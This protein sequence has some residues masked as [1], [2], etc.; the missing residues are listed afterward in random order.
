MWVTAGTSGEFDWVRSTLAEN[1]VHGS[2][3]FGYFVNRPHLFRPSE[4]DERAAMPVL[5]ELL[6]SL[7]DGKVV[8]ATARHLRRPSARTDA[9]VP[10]VQAFRR[11]APS[12]HADAGWALGD[13]MASA[14]G[15]K[16]AEILLSLAADPAYGPARQMIVHS[17]W[18][19]RKDERV[20]E[21]LPTLARDPDVSLHAMSA[22]RRAM[23]NEA[24]RPLL[25]E[26]AESGPDQRVREQAAR[27]L[28]K[29]ERAS[30]R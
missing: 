8:A 16:D 20:V 24:A 30:R 27:E 1:G 4:F 13:A 19:F 10:L 14:A 7:T 22:L 25:R 23:G 21:A 26:L 11:W 28:R 6:P 5:L 12:A 15:P 29:A 3:D 9:F 2:S 18:R 17:L